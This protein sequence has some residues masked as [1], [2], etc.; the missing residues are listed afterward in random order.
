MRLRNGK[1]V[2]KRWTPN[3]IAELEKALRDLFARMEGREPRQPNRQLPPPIELTPEPRPE[4]LKLGHAPAFR[5]PLVVKE[6]LDGLP[7]AMLEG[8]AE[9]F[10]VERFGGIPEI[11]RP[12]VI[13]EK[14][15]LKQERKS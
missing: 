9:H 8:R 11:W 3:G 1:P 6:L 2:W 12:F 4:P 14:E 10:W 5:Q 15:R 7:K 13:A